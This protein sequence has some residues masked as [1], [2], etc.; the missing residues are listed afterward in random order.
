MNVVCLANHHR[1]SAP[2]DGKPRDLIATPSSELRTS[3][4]AQPTRF[5][6]CPPQNMPPKAQPWTRSTFGPFMAIV[7]S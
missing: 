1:E 7:E 6:V 2:I 4:I 3:R 5:Q